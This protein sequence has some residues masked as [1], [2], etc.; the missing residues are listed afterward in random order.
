MGLAALVHQI[1]IPGCS[2]GDASGE[3]GDVVCESN[4][5][6]PILQEMLANSTSIAGLVWA[7]TCRHSWGKL[8]LGT[9]PLLPTHMSML[10]PV[11]VVTLT[12]SGSVI[13]LTIAAAFL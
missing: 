9:A 13:C 3:G 7:H 10:Q 6:G 1:F 8:S 2:Y 11:P 5:E 12:F 4:T